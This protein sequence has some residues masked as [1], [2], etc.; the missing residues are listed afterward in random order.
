MK[1]LYPSQPDRHYDVITVGEST[2]D[3]FM[4]LAQ[5]GSLHADGEHGGVCFKLGDKID[6]DRY[7]FTIGGNATNVAVGLTRLGVKS[8]LVSETGDDEF[9]IKIRNCLASEHIERLWVNQ[10]AGAS[11]FSVIINYGGDRT[12]FVQDVQRE[13]D[14]Q[15]ED[16]TTDMVYLTSLGREWQEPYKR[17]VEFAKKN[18]AKLAF[19]PGSRQLHEGQETIK[20]VLKHTETL[21]INKEEGEH[22][23]YGEKKVDSPNSK[24]YI[25]KLLLKLTK[26]GP[27]MIVLTNGKFGSHAID[28]QKKFYFQG[29]SPGKAVERTGA[30]DAFATGFLA[31]AI[32]GCC[33]PDAMKWG[34]VNAA[35]VVAHIGAQAGLLNKEE[36]ED[37]V[38]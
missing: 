36:M 33:L 6:V 14:F 15:F 3:T 12:I 32:H 35:S 30:G 34:S 1:H 23:L 4:T 20:Y 22:L 24:E 21:F 27:K 5:P 31:G 28:G 38:M 19:N 26:L 9:S 2:I 17:A 10:V 8:T 37:L 16:V 11:N 18:K 13:H 7:D 29:M 25:E